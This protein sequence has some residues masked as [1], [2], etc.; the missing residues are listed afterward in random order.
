MNLADIY[1]MKKERNAVGLL[2]AMR[3]PSEHVRKNAVIALCSFCN[4]KVSDIL[5]EMKYKDP[6]PTVRQA[7]ARGQEMLALR[8]GRLQ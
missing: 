6:S 4:V 2:R 3:D 8:L 5:V 1:Q 7:A